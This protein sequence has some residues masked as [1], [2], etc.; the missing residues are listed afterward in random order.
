MGAYV[1]KE[2]AFFGRNRARDGGPGPVG[3][4]FGQR[5]GGE[6]EKKNFFQFFCVNKQRLG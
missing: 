5:G 1:R 3:A 2:K 6:E 4:Q